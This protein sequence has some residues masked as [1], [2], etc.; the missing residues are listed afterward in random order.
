M[1][2]S[3]RHFLAS[4]GLA[5][6]SVAVMATE[7][8]AASS[9]PKKHKSAKH[10]TTAQTS[11]KPAKHSSGATQASHKPHKSTARPSTQS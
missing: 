8:S 4:L 2:F 1:T 5:L 7:A 9:T 3:R 11:H 10:N 6:P